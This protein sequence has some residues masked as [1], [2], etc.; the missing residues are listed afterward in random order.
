MTTI[1]RALGFAFGSA[2]ATSILTF[3]TSLY[4]ARALS[5]AEIG[6]FSIAA[7]IGAIAT[8]LRGMGL[9]AYIVQEQELTP[10]RIRTASGVLFLASWSLGLLMVLG[11]GPVAR[12][13]DN[14]AIAELLKILAVG[15][16]F[17]PIG[18]TTLSLL[19]RNLQFGVT[20]SIEV[21]SS[22]A[23]ACTAV[24][25][26]SQGFGYLS[27]A[28]ASVAGIA[29]TAILSLFF[30]D[31]Q[32]HWFPNLKEWRRVLG[33]GVYVVGGYLV[34]QLRGSAYELIVGKIAGPTQ[35]AFLAR[36]G[37]LAGFL[38]NIVSGA[39]QKVFFS[40]LGQDIREGRE[41]KSMY[42]KIL[43]HTTGVAWP[44]LAVLGI[45][46]GPVVLTLYGPQW[47]ASVDLARYTALAT[48]LGVPFWMFAQILNAFG[49]AKV[50]MKYQLVLLA[51]AIIVAIVVAPYGIYA[52]AVSSV[53]YTLITGAMMWWILQPLVG[54]RVLDFLR[55]CKS[56]FL[57]TL[58]CSVGAL[59]CLSIIGTRLPDWATMLIGTGVSALLWL[60]G[61]FWLHHPV[62]D[63]LVSVVDKLRVRLYSGG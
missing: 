51:L 39:I 45:L 9:S 38:S 48:A 50:L 22:V 17:I 58:L 31:T 52:L 5:P 27:L 11:S 14:D 4:I 29:M 16:G 37:G 15:F 21:A 20:S 34:G 24:F 61:L 53:P 47:L 13:Y 62:A 57:L 55:A 12:Y 40:Y 25:L 28:W 3:V 60:G 35:L 59:A 54:F 23:S 2:Y 30:R 49:L 46:S 10:D 33:F 42:L 56:S 43:T 7:A 36:A 44:M 26:A 6:L 41:I 8:K 63:E 32:V 19:T 18:G 1:R